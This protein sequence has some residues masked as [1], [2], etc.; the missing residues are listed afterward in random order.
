L[1]AYYA[2]TYAYFIPV[3]RK[4]SFKAVLT[5]IATFDVLRINPVAVSVLRCSASTVRQ[6]V[7]LTVLTKKSD[8]D[9]YFRPVTVMET[10]I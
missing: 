1:L 5:Y 2:I 10:D 4:Q 3:F 8:F 6:V 7:N 9:G